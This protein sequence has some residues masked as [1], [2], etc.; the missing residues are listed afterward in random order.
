[1]RGLLLYW[2]YKRRDVLYPFTP[3]AGVNGGPFVR[4]AGT[5][6]LKHLM[7]SAAKKHVQELPGT[8]PR[9]I[10]QGKFVAHL[11]VLSVFTL[12]FCPAAGRPA[13]QRRQ[14][15]I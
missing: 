13:R 2:A 11:C 9:V 6:L 1:M 10:T 5:P 7:L 4:V 14:H 15:Q 3:G 8:L 12:R